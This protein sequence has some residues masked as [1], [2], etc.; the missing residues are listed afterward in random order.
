MFALGFS[1]EES[2][3]RASKL[4][5]FLMQFPCFQSSILGLSL[6]VTTQAVRAPNHGMG[7]RRFREFNNNGE[8][9]PSYSICDGGECPYIFVRVGLRISFVE[10]T[11]DLMTL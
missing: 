11:D 6:Q 8:K 7:C 3:R 10:T 2:S 4:R 1:T 5:E 9:P